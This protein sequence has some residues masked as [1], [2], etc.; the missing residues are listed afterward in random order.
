MQ[1]FEVGHVGDDHSQEIVEFPGHKI[2]LHDFGNIAHGLLE[3]RQLAFFL[4]VQA[5]MHEYVAG[6]AHLGLAHERGVAI[7][8]AGLFERANAPQ[9]GGLGQADQAGELH[10]ADATVL[11]QGVEDQLVEFV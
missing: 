8:H 11:L 9:A 3:G 5:D 10:I 4:A 6:K 7:D 1:A 2:T